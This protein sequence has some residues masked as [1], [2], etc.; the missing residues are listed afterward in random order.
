VLCDIYIR[1]DMGLSES[2]NVSFIC[3]GLLLRL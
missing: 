2:A 1:S 3:S